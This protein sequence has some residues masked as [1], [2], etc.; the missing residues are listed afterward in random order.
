MHRKCFISIKDPNVTPIFCNPYPI[1]LIHKQ[2]FQRELQHLVDKKVFRRIRRSE[3]AFPT[4]LIPKNMTESVGS[5]ISVA[6]TS[7]SNIFVIFFPEYM[8]L[9]KKAGFSHIIKLDI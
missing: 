7:C 9:G 1:P 8:Y 2:V 4:F 5:M 3:W 6:L